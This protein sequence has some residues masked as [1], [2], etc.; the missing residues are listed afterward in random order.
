MDSNGQPRPPV[1]VSFE[2][3]FCANHVAD[4]T[5][6]CSFRCLYCP[7][8]AIGARLR[9]VSRPAA[10]DLS[11]LNDLT[12][13]QS[14]FLSPA[15]DAFA[16]QA[17]ES[18]HTLLSYLLPRGT[19]VGIVTKGIVPERTLALLVEHRLQVEGVA[20]GVTSL[21]DHR[22]TVLEPGCPPARRRLDN[23][24]RLAGR[25]LPAALRLDPLFPVL[26]DRPAAL[27]A[28]VKEAA[29]RGAYAVT[30]TYV[31]A[32]GRYLRRLQREPLLAESCRLLTERAPMEGGAAFSV[33]LA[34]KL[35]T[36][37]FLADVASEHGLWFNT[38]GCK[39]WRVRESG[40]VFASCRN[41]LFLKRPE[42]RPTRTGA[43]PGPEAA[44]L[45]GPRAA[46]PA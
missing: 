10:L 29:R 3:R 42:D 2:P 27:T 28:L 38:C 23:I 30:A 9:G 35:E 22:N 24:E 26:D 32:W 15:S 14:I 18:T 39:D 44:A 41:V 31:F 6:G 1:T 8:A 4:L 25:G 12:P 17:V 7:F 43:R 11:R 16:P 21:D 34:R 13:P 19:T 5:A 33:P 37:G 36:Y 40:R 46:R 45:A 20:V